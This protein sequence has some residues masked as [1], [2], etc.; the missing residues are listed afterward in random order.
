MSA[1]KE[2]FGVTKKFRNVDIEKQQ[3]ILN[4]ALQEFTEKEYDLASTNKIVKEAGIGKGMLFYYFENKK[5]LYDY[6][7][8]Y[9]IEV[10]EREYLEVIDFS[11]R[12]LFERMKSLSGIKWDFMMKHAN[13]INFIS[14]LFLKS[15]E[16]LDIELKVRF[17]AIQVKWY[18][19]IYENIDLTLFREDINVEKAFALV[20]WAIHGY[21]EDLK[22][23]LRD[24]DLITLD[25]DSYYEE[26]FEY[27][28]VLKTVFYKNEVNV[29]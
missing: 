16:N 2:G 18:S 19:I 27:L 23:R 14:T 13:E 11:A 1:R 6:L 28:E 21:E 22:Y 5:G 12:D 15:P 26:F 7:I 3:Q 8:D 24:Q 29:K 17:E 10:I 25:Y 9:C 4:A 20:Q